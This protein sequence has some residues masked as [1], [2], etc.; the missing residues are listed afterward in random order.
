[1]V[2]NK[3]NSNIQGGN[4]LVGLKYVKIEHSKLTN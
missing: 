2:R 3:L 4:E 1:M